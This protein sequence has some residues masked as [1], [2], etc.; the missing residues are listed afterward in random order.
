MPK[1]GG[2]VSG[3]DTDTILAQ[4]KAIAQRPITKLTARKAELDTRTAAWDAMEVKFV[5][6][7]T[8]R[9]A[10]TDM[11][12]T[13]PTMVTSSDTALLTA[14]VT[15]TAEV[16]V[17]VVKVTQM[18]R[19]EESL[20][21]NFCGSGHA[22]HGRRYI[23]IESGKWHGGP[24]P[25]RDHVALRTQQRDGVT[26]GT[27]RITDRSGTSAVIDLSGNTTVQD[28]STISPPREG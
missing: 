19:G 15:G 17:R 22:G 5:G 28:I 4:L 9:K 24:R 20:S 21:N 26:L 1:I 27:I 8:A 12:A 18:A 2:I 14:Q 25:D 23:D 11:F 13:R 16:G 10:L 6:L 3:M 7:R